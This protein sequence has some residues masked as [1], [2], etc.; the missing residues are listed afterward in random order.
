[1][2]REGI[3]GRL[4]AAAGALRA[5][6]EDRR[7][8]PAAARAAD[9]DQGR[10]HVV[11]VAQLA[12]RAIRVHRVDQQVAARAQP[13]DVDRLA[14]ELGVVVVAPAGRDA[15]LDAVGA[16]LALGAVAVAIARRLGRKAVTPRGLGLVAI[17]QAEA[18]LV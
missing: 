10:G 16:R 4:A 15:L 7:R 18:G 9:P 3:S 1:M 5:A 2:A 8:A 12:Q 13:G 14:L 6:R 17:A 11:P